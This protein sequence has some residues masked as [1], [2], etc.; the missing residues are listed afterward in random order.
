MER[1]EAD[2][3]IHH[4]ENPKTNLITL[5]SRSESVISS[6]VLLIGGIPENAKWSTDKILGWL[7][8]TAA[9]FQEHAQIRPIIANIHLNLASLNYILFPDGHTF[10]VAIPIEPQLFQIGGELQPNSKYEF[11]ILSRASDLFPITSQALT[12]AI[13][14]PPVHGRALYH[15]LRSGPRR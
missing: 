3:V 8:Q 11:G 14:R 5:A 10:S 9:D 12:M 4:H 15:P 2:V 6:N 13:R 7:L 1:F